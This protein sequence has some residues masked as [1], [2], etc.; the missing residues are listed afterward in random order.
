[1]G[2]SDIERWYERYFPLIR[3]KC[4]RMLGD[5]DDAQDLAQDTFIRLWRAELPLTDTRK[6][7]SWVYKTATRLAIDRLRARAVREAV[8]DSDAVDAG[9]FGVVSARRQVL[10]LA[11]AT[12]ADELEA[13]LLDRLD[14]LTQAESAEVLGV[15]ERTVRRLLERFDA[16]VAAQREA[17]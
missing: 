10:A 3:E 15:S 5:F 16:R 7:T 4:R 8:P 9:P 13:A 11:R 2:A 17:P 6:V 12:P 1:V 14:G